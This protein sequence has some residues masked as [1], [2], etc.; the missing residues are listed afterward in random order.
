MRSDDTA[1]HADPAWLR[2][3]GTGRAGA[4]GDA[5]RRFR[6]HRLALGGLAVIGVL[7]GLAVAA[8]A[9]TWL[10][11]LADPL[12]I[13]ADALNQP[14]G[15]AHPL[16][17]DRLGRDILARTVYGARI[18]LSIAVLIQL[19]IL[20]IGGTI[21]MTA[22]LAGGRLDT[23][24]MRATDVVFAFPDLL[25]VLVIAAVLGAGYWSIVA[26]VGLVNW[27][28]L[29]RL[30]R[31]EVLSITQQ[32]YIAAARLAG[33][34]PAAVMWRHLVPN[35]LGPVIV[36]A[37]FSIPAAIFTEAFL[38]FVGVGLRPPTPSWGLMI[39]EG[40]QAIFAHPHQVA[41]PAVA[42][43]LATLAFNFTGDGLRDALDVR[44]RGRG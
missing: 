25:F 31:G 30:V 10:G 44:R 14:P 9:L 35:S 28:F 11:V 13:D 23:V 32:D 19:V 7:A 8:P 1:V 18:S 39:E 2:P 37:T 26:A 22:G 33:R 17:T 41:A 36:N 5:W 29:A 12:A 21:G 34:P 4:S 6:T 24:L 38:S 42:I 40:Y 27:A 43:S 3:A 16:G 15:P 20:A